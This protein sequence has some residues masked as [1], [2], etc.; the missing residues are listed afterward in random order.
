[1]LR[2]ARRKIVHQLFERRLGLDTEGELSREAL[3]IEDEEY[4]YY[5]PSSWIAVPLA[6][7]WRTPTGDDVLLDVGSGKGRVALQA[8]RYPFRRIIGLE[9]VPE[10]VEAARKNLSRSRHR[11]RCHDVTFVAGNIRDFTIP[12]DVTI[13]YCCDP[14]RGSTFAIFVE[15]LVE[16]VDRRGS[17]VLL[18]YCH[19]QEHHQLS[20]NPA[21]ELVKRFRPGLALEFPLHIYEVRPHN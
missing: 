18:I 7:R 9:L 3:G 5:V 20:I 16:L 10:L 15:R 11:L 4:G 2:A 6:L 12:D 21:I 13:A 14:F 8:A 1:M 19:P 17:P